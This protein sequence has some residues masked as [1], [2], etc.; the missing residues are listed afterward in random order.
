MGAGLTG[1]AVSALN[2]FAV[3]AQSSGAV[4]PYNLDIQTIN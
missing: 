2:N 3:Y 4:V 1:D